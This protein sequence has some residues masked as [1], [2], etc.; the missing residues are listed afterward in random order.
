MTADEIAH[1]EK[2]IQTC[3]API[4]AAM[5]SLQTDVGTIAS[6]QGKMLDGLLALQTTQ[7]TLVEQ[8]NS[9]GER[10][11][12][13]ETRTEALTASFGQL[14]ARIAVSLG[15]D[16]G[17]IK[18]RLGRLSQDIIQARTGETDRY[19]LLERRVEAIEARLAA[20]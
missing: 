9:L 12:S 4:V 11:G 19:A 2:I 1:I 14:S 20:T 3:Q 15:V 10:I 7:R 8:L 5:Q 16:L 6:N 17:E 18:G 13:G